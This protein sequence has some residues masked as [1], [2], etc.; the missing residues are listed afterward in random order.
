LREYIDHVT[1][2]E[3]DE[4]LVLV[5][6]VRMGGKSTPNHPE[7]IVDTHTPVRSFK[8]TNILAYP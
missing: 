2:S 5:D 1:C 4:L 8:A 3:S 6:K 7:I